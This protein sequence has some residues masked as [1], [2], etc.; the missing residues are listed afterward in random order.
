MHE[1]LR[2]HPE[3]FM[4]ADKELHYF[5]ADLK[6]R[7]P[8]LTEVQYLEH[9]RAARDETRVGESS[10]W[11]LYSE[12]AA[13]EIH[14]FS[15]DARII[16]MLRNP[17][18]MLYSQHNQFLYNGN[19]N[20]T[21]FSEALEAEEERKKGLRIPPDAMLVQGLFYRDTAR[22]AD[23]VKR[24]LDVFGP[25]RVHIILYDDFKQ[26]PA[27]VY[28]ETLEFLGVDP[29]FQPELR[30]INP[31]KR[32]RWSGLHRLFLTPP[33]FLRRIVRGLLPV[34][35]WRATLLGGVFR[36]N[37]QYAPQQPMS[38]DLRR[39]LQESFRGDI[40]NLSQLIR[41]DLSRWFV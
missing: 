4:T 26:D 25:A 12:T 31:S 10:V 16:I 35:A 1:Y 5:G 15:P 9:F 36:W 29:G 33:A 30:V 40:E 20:I 32:F 22:Y 39:S 11:Y 37:V 17:P 6:I 14:A 23:Q 3:I 21:N 2:A 28:T 13:E 38:P 41:R 18:D 8:R 19:E 24:Y 7:P 27:G 34:Q